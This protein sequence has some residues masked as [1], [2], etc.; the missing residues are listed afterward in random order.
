MGLEFRWLMFG[1]VRHF[2]QTERKAETARALMKWRDVAI[3]LSPADPLPHVAHCLDA[4]LALASPVR[5]VLGRRG[6]T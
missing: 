4:L 2:L 1:E 3:N 5:T 6:R